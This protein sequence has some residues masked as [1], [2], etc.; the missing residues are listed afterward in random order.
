MNR[1]FLVIAAIVLIAGSACTAPRATEIPKPA[2]ILPS[3][4]PT[5]MIIRANPESIVVEANPA[6]AVRQV[7]TPSTA[8]PT[9]TP[10]P[11]PTLRPP[12]PTATFPPP[13]PTAT[14]RP[15]APTVTMTAR[16]ASATPTANPNDWPT[17][18]ARL[19]PPEQ[20]A[21][22]QQQKPQVSAQ[23][24]TQSVKVSDQALAGKVWRQKGCEIL[25]FPDDLEFFPSEKRIR[26]TSGY[27]AR[28]FTTYQILA[29]GRIEVI[30]KGTLT[31]VMLYT[32]L[33]FTGNSLTLQA[34]EPNFNKVVACTYTR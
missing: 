34:M 1:F 13:A 19:A 17:G 11:T 27:A 29:D 24:S 23:A 25:A 10:P 16:P 2:Q 21:Q 32:P 7:A 3:A 6:Q 9:P 8:P 15:Q 33:S 31:Q 20:T 5:Q 12:T 28:S 14:S 4:T 22:A 18:V 30:Y 26:S